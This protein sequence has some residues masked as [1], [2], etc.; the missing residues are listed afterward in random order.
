MKKQKETTPVFRI[1]DEA[2]SGYYH[3]YCEPQQWNE[4]KQRW[5]CFSSSF[6]DLRYFILSCQCS[7]DSPVPYAWSA[8]Y[9][10]G[11]VDSEN[12]GVIAKTLAKIDKGLKRMNEEEG[13]A[14]SYGQFCIRVA[15]T[16]G[17]RKFLVYQGVDSH[18]HEL[19]LSEAQFRIDSL[20]ADW[21]EKYRNKSAA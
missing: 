13:A 4:N 18:L 17:I 15:R 9:R 7:A 2:K 1:Y 3:V 14:L 12:I 5:E 6:D 21:L 8:E 20:T 16:L 19:T 11:Y 10:G